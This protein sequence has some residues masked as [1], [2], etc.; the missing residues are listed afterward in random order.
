MDAQ[1]S[2]AAAVAVAAKKVTATRYRSQ[3]SSQKPASTVDSTRAMS[4]FPQKTP[5]AAS[6]VDKVRSF[7]SG[8]EWVFWVAGGGSRP[9]CLF[10]WARY[11]GK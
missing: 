4:A 9:R 6:K 8:P 3:Y 11:L 5:V 10:F 1:R 2:G 7:V